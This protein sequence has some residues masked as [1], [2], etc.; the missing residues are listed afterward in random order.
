MPAAAY[1][2][3]VQILNGVQDFFYC[4]GNCLARGADA[5]I[6]ALNVYY[7]SRDKSRSEAVNIRDVGHN[8]NHHLK[9]VEAFQ[10]MLA[11]INSAGIAP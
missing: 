6:D 1:T 4:Q 9:R 7:P 5:T 11:F 3:P 2:K 10:K 8:V